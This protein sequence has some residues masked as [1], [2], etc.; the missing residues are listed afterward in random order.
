MDKLY[1]THK[2]LTTMLHDRGYDVNN[3]NQMTLSEFE[4]KYPNVKIYLI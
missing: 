4:K 3:E 1:Q 2:T